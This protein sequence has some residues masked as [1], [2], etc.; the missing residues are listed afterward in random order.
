MGNEE[1]KSISSLMTETRT[2]PPSKESVARAHVK[3]AEEYTK[4]WE[5][6]LK[7]PDKFWLEQ[8]GTLAWYKQPTKTLEYT[9]D[10]EG[11][12]IRHTWFA[13]GELNVSYNCLGG[14]R[15]PSSGRGMNRRK[16]GPI[17]IRTCTRKCASL[18][19]S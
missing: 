6:S 5:Q 13:D 8:A 7:E 16:T 18:P 14:T 1:K 2:F 10:T 9:W 11:R 3:S 17:P 15:S 4:M 12:N 19:T